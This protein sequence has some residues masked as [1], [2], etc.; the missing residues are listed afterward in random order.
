MREKV[1]ELKALIGAK[2]D[3]RLATVLGL[4]IHCIAKWKAG[5]TRPSYLAQEKIDALVKKHSKG[6]KS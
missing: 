2:S 3:Q 6:A 4:S 5:K 1:A